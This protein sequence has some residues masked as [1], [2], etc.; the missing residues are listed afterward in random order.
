MVTH[1]LEYK[2]MSKHSRPAVDRRGESMFQGSLDGSVDIDRRLVDYVWTHLY[3]FFISEISSSILISEISS[4][5]LIS[6]ISSSTNSLSN[7]HEESE[8][9]ERLVKRGFGGEKVGLYSYI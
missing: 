3:T 4:S 5:I 6:E 7:L 2:G 8:K 1:F 9:F